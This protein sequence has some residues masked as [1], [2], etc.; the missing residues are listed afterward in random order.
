MNLNT[1]LSSSFEKKINALEILTDMMNMSKKNSESI[2]DLM[3][4]LLLIVDDSGEIYR[5]N[6]EV[7]NLLKKPYDEI[8]N[9]NLN[10]LF[11]QEDFE[12]LIKFITHSN[13]FPHHNSLVIPVKEQWTNNKNR[14]FNN[15]QWRTNKLN[16]PTSKQLNLFILSGR[17]VGDLLWS[18]HQLESLNNDLENKIEERTAE[19]KLAHQRMIKLSHYTGMAEV[20]S[21]ILHNLGNAVTS[22]FGNLQIFKRKINKDNQLSPESKEEYDKIVTKLLKQVENMTKVIKTQEKYVIKNVYKEKLTLSQVLK[23]SLQ[24][25]KETFREENIT[26]N[27]THKDEIVIDSSPPKLNNIFMLIFANAIMA[28]KNSK[29]KQIDIAV[30]KNI[31]CIKDNGIGI[32]EEDIQKIFNHGFTT[33]ENHDGHGLHTAINLIKELGGSIVASSPGINMGAEFILTFSEKG[34]YNYDASK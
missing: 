15:Y 33:W 17:F 18:N 16:T 24:I 14:I 20:A 26:I 3:N 10:I 4:D 27:F 28:L 23:D 7:L 13:L 6:K 22:A 2:F 25:L 19:L 8:I 32:K 29:N 1:H 34:E 12:K 11:D 5:I 31:V 30:H 9:T 21:N